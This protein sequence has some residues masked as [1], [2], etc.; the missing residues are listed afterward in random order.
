VLEVALTKDTRI[1]IGRAH[2]VRHARA[3]HILAEGQ[4][5][6]FGDCEEGCCAVDCRILGASGAVTATKNYFIVTNHSSHT[7][8]RVANQQYSRETYYIEPLAANRPI[9]FATAEL[10]GNNGPALTLIAPGPSK[11][12]EDVCA[13]VPTY[14]KHGTKYFKV[15]Q[16]LC[17]PVLADPQR[18]PPTVAAIADR[19]G[20][21][22][23]AV[24]HH[25]NY[26]VERC[27]LTPPGGSYTGWQIHALVDYA[28]AH[29]ALLATVL[30][31]AK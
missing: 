5:L 16:A 29:A 17:E 14:F 15:F 9:P 12:A 22:E 20:I 6:K 23:T 21:S 11:A 25:L 26:L 4:S 31:E 8:L 1:A 24:S 13:G 18:R 30:R 10:S 3:T 28:V 2:I 27:G 19:V 7:A